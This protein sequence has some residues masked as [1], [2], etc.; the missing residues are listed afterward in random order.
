MKSCESMYNWAK[1]LAEKIDDENDEFKKKAPISMN[2][3][4]K[5]VTQIIQWY[6]KVEEWWKWTCKYFDFNDEKKDESQKFSKWFI[7]FF[8]QLDKYFPKDKKK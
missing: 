6:K 8:D 3:V 1:Q 4:V 5:D 7:E 2:Q